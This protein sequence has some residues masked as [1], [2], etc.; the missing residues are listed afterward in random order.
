M[1]R[2]AKIPK[3]K[4]VFVYQLDPN[5][6]SRVIAWWE[7]I[8]K[9]NDFIARIPADYD[10]YEMYWCFSSDYDR[11]N[12]PSSDGKLPHVT[13]DQ[14]FCTSKNY[15]GV[16]SKYDL[17]GDYIETISIEEFHKIGCGIYKVGTWHTIWGWPEFAGRGIQ[18]RT[19]QQGFHWDF[20]KVDSILTLMIPERSIPTVDPV[21]LKMLSDGEIQAYNPI[22]LERAEAS[23]ARSVAKRKLQNETQTP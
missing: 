21:R 14:R 16:V 11:V 17:N 15:D 20:A 23:R 18:V 8:S 4:P 22:I 9:F 6:H 5:D 2:P 7:S 13:S 3:H 1:A 10:E 12:G 19:A